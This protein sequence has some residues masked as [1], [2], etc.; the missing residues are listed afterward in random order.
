MLYTYRQRPTVHVHKRSS[1]VPY[2]RQQLPAHSVNG[3][4][5]WI[6]AL[7]GNLRHGTDR[8]RLL[9]FAQAV[10]RQPQRKNG[11]EPHQFPHRHLLGGQIARTRQRP[12][13]PRPIARSAQGPCTP[14]TPAMANYARLRIVKPSVGPEWKGVG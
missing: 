10:F 14:C 3:E 11:I 5:P 8:T 4:K 9:V 2:P 6:A 12:P 13:R 1:A 7:S